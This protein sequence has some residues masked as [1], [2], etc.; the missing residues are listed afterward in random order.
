MGNWKNYNYNKIYFK[1]QYYLKNKYITIKDI[2]KYIDGLSN[3][4][5]IVDSNC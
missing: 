2:K 4:Y 3:Y 1:G 5:D